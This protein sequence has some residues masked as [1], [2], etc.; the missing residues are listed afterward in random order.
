MQMY[1]SIELQ[2]S[3]LLKSRLPTTELCIH[4]QDNMWLSVDGKVFTPLL[5]N[6]TA[7]TIW[8]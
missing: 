8:R 4:E 2:L 1:D 6:N 3:T 5:P 7:S